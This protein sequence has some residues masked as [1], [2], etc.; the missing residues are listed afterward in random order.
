MNPLDTPEAYD[1]IILGGL[2]SPGIVEVTGAAREAEW[3]EP[4]AKGSSGAEPTYNGQKL[5]GITCKFKFWEASQLDEW[6]R[7]RTILEKPT[8]AKEPRPLDII[9]PLVNDLGITSVV[10]DVEGQLVRE[11]GCLWTVEVK[12]KE[13]RKPTPAGAG[14]LGGSVANAA[15]AGSTANVVELV[16]T[17]PYQQGPGNPYLAGP[18]NEYTGELMGAQQEAIVAD[19]QLAGAAGSPP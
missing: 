14:K 3:D 5:S 16:S 9:H 15:G 4:K 12:F 17:D 19:Q 10:V 7:F 18:A 8:D 2:T 13:R 6:R 1:V 11:T